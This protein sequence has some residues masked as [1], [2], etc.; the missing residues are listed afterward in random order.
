MKHIR[1][2]NKELQSKYQQINEAYEDLVLKK[3]NQGENHLVKN[4]LKTIHEKCMKA[5]EAYK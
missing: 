3:P 1:E 5:K 4:L 2:E